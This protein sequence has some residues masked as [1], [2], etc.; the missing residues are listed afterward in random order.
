MLG[1]ILDFLK[2]AAMLAF[3]SAKIN[4]GLHVVSKLPDGYHAIE[5]VFY[6]VKIQDAVELVDASETSLLLRGTAIP[7]AVDDNLCL[8]VFRRMQADFKLPHQQ[9]V[10]LKNIPVGAGLGGGSSDAASILR[11]VNDKFSLQLSNDAL[12]DYAR[13]FGADCAFFIQ[14]KPVF[15]QGK[16]D[17][18]EPLPID[19]SPYFLV[20]V[21]PPVH[22][23]TAG[24]YRRVQVRRPALSLKEMVQQPLK[25]WKELV[26]N[27][28]E[29]S[30]A[31]LYPEIDEIKTKLYEAGATFA[32]MSGSGSAVF[33]IFTQ[34]VKLPGLEQDNQV[35]Y[36]V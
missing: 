30:V 16:G 19:L 15:A 20:V 28:F 7:G 26:V 12:L 25:N 11:L 8:R 35:F 9:L 18:F 17:V 6:P 2:F 24:A 5:T 29:A 23:D 31:A 36:G 1:S 4:I 10:L 14:G 3:A 22:S 32:L 21:K 27:D 34:P 33:G 13:S